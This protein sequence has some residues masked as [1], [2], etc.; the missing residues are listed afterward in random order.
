M[1]EGRSGVGMTILSCCGCP[2]LLVCGTIRQPS[3][4]IL[5]IVQYLLISVN[6]DPVF[7]D[8][9]LPVRRWLMAVLHAAFACCAAAHDLLLYRECAPIA[10]RDAFGLMT[11][12]MEV[13]TKLH[14]EHTSAEQIDGLRD[15]MSPTALRLA[16]PLTWMTST[17]TLLM[18][19]M[20]LFM[21]AL[22]LNFPFLIR[23]TASLTG[24]LSGAI[25]SGCF[26]SLMMSISV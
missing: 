4:L 6:I 1:R 20:K 7:F 14:T 13:L 8:G 5:Q 18:L 21:R 26:D 3:L 22:A 16:L 23:L 25:K 24:L 11:E 10:P 2:S 19:V 12:P 15:C 17:G 9:C